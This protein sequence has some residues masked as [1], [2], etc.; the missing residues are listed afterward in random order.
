MNPIAG[1]SPLKHESKK[2]ELVDNDQSLSK[3]P[4]AKHRNAGPD[5]VTGRCAGIENALQDQKDFTE[6]LNWIFCGADI[7]DQQRA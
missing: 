5:T 6:N 4:E 7:R 1:Q 3:M 2:T